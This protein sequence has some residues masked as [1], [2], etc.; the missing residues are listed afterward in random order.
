MRGR[1]YVEDG[2]ITT[3]AAVTSGVPAALH[4]VAELAGPAEA[5]RVAD[6]HP[7]LGWTPT[8]TTR[9][10]EDHF[11]VH[12]WPVG[13]NYVMPW[14]RP[15]V[16]IALKDG[17]GELDATAAFE[18]YGQS[19]AARTVALATSD[20]VRTRHGLVLLTT[21]FANA[22]GLSRLVVVPGA[23]TADA[24]DP[25]LRAWADQQRLS[26]EPLT[27]LP[28]PDGSVGGGGFSAALQNL[29]DHADPATTSATAK[30]IGYPTSNLNGGKQHRSLRAVLLGIAGL[31]LA[32]LV[33]LAPAFV[34][35]RGRRRSLR[36]ANASA[37]VSLS[38]PDSPSLGV[39]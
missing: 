10:P 7:E 31:A 4:L 34:A 32:V 24:V 11:T 30:M 28:G 14:F 36:R 6:L 21:S 20:T 37:T 38:D 5:Q 25:Q 18:V 39:P 15:T 35:R 3:T 2:S 8:A 22:P 33:G 1:R 9:I 12:D 19:A 27:A 17:V 23:D 29:A 26:V 13:L 16:G